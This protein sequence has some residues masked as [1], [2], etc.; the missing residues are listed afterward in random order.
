[1]GAEINCLFLLPSQTQH[2]GTHSLTQRPLEEWVLSLHW[3]T[4][5]SLRRLISSHTHT[6]WYV[7]P[8]P[9]RRD[10]MCILAY[11]PGNRATWMANGIVLSPCRLIATEEAE[12]AARR[13]LWDFLFR[14]GSV[15]PPRVRP[16]P[17]PLSFRF[18]YPRK[19]KHL[20]GGFSPWL[21]GAPSGLAS[22]GRWNMKI[23]RLLFW[24]FCTMFQGFFLR[25]LRS[26]LSLF[27][28]KKM[29]SDKWS[30]SYWCSVSDNHQTLGF[31]LWARLQWG[32]NSSRQN[33]TLL[34]ESIK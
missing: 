2:K 9:G 14:P 12:Y 18:N 20:Q 6:R 31:C 11:T 26:Y 19:K 27:F 28:P 21:S 4:S 22:V 3:C 10:F 25:T 17:R 34:R 13:L 5:P 30:L 16:L 15:W 1:M 8:L 24:L 33:T 29:R 32:R 23:M 7:F